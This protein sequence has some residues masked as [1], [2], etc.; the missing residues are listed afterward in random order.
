M[1]SIN[2]A[3]RTVKADLA[4]RLD[5]D[6]IHQRCRDLGRRWR[7]RV[8][9]PATTLYV[10]AMQILA[11]NTAC[12]HL[13][14]LAKLRFSDS[15]YCQAR[16]RLPLALFQGLTR[17]VGQF[18]GQVGDELGLWRGHRIWLA[19]GSNASMPDTPAL[20]EHFGQP[21]NQK[22]GCGFPVGSLLL[23]VHAASGAI[24]DVLIRPLRVHDM[25][26]V[27]EIHPLLAAGDV[28]VGDRA[29]SSYAHLCL[30]LG[31]GLHG[32]FRVHQRVIVSFRYRRRHARLLPRR[33]RTGR[34]TSQWIRRLG[35]SDQVVRYFKPRQCPR[36]M[37][38]EQYDA[39]PESIQVRELR[40]RTNRKGFRTK[41]VTLVTTLLD[42]A[43]YPATELAD[44]FFNRWAIEGDLDHLKTT[45]GAAVLHCKSVD[46]VTKELWM[47]LL[48]YNLVRQVMLQAAERQAAAVARMSFVDALRWLACAELGEELCDL[49]VNPLR[50]GRVEPR[51]LKRRLKAYTRMDRPRK[52][53]KREIM[54]K[55]AA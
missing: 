44:Q 16:A 21:S 30:L 14:H 20:R 32:I 39:L 19:D 49:V 53:L 1:V 52:E 51:V 37:S 26:G 15:A 8:L 43:L 10:F 3:L 54:R 9:D 7:D 2:H 48:I 50:E 12:T 36:W 28:L 22:E 40:Y 34:P 46:G 27:A 25:S 24:R 38:H 55:R 6:A 23:L 47:F 13:R 29:F 33:Q 17:A 5:P 41:E 11:G 45:M 31:R 18:V 42:P 35:P 4:Q